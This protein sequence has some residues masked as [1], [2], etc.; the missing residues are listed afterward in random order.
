MEV[1][2]PQKFQALFQPSRY[3]AFYGGRGSAKSHSFAAALVLLAA[4]KPLRILCGREIQ[5]SI[6]DSVKRLIDDKIKE[7]GLSKF[8]ESTET[9][10][11]GKNGSLFLFAGIKTNPES[12]KSME[13]IDICW[14]EEASTIS[15]RSLEFL[16]PTIR[17]EGSEIWFSWNPENELDPVDIMFRGGKIPP[18]SIVVEVQAEDNPWFPSVLAQEMEF[19]RLNNPSKYLHIWRGGYRLTTEGAYYAKQIADAIA[20][21]RITRLPFESQIPVIAS[22][23]LGISDMTSIWF[24]QVVGA[25]IRVIDF[26]QSNGQPI[27]WYAKQLKEKPYIY[28]TLILPHDARAKS[29]GTGKSIEEI[30]KN[31]GFTTLICPNIPIKDG[32]D[33]ARSFLGKC[34]FD[35]DKTADGLKSLRAYRENYDDKLRISRGPLHDEHSHAADAFRYLAVGLPK[36]KIKTPINEVVRSFYKN[37]TPDSD[38]PIFR[39]DLTI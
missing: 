35:Q 25:E 12:I 6:K 38:A 28:D 20:E 26:L 29:L 11:R 3:K 21:N 18:N 19:D 13:G 4:Q 15:L 30:L 27:D 39:P 32:I 17:K 23:D 1:L 16:I 9:E 22:F 7:F 33:N 14:I 24:A 10:I 36:Q 2:I 8:F 34:W 31:M 37:L 5:K